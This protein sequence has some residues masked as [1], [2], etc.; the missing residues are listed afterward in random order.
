MSLPKTLAP[1]TVIFAISLLASLG[2]SATLVGTN[3]AGGVLNSSLN[4]FPNQVTCSS[5]AAVIANAGTYA[6]TLNTSPRVG[7]L[8]LGGGIGQQTLSTAARRDASSWSDGSVMGG[9]FGN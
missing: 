7:S 2:H 8:P 1:V 4:W 6:V 5:D 9:R 3:T